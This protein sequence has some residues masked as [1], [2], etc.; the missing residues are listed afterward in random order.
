MLLESRIEASKSASDTLWILGGRSAGLIIDA[1]CH[2]SCVARSE[3]L[4]S[5]STNLS[6]RDQISRAS[7]GKSLD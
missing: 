4:I 5:E 1:K 3:L 7:T 2:H 6:Q